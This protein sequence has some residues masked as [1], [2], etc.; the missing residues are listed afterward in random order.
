M[1][2]FFLFIQSVERLE[3][4]GSPLFHW[5]TTTLPLATRRVGSH[6]PLIEIRRQP[7]VECFAQQAGQC[8]RTTLGRKRDRHTRSTHD[9]AGIRTRVRGIVDSIHKHLPMLCRLEHLLVDLRRRRRNDIPGTI[10][11]GRLEYTLRDRHAWL[12]QFRSNLWCDDRHE[13]TVSQKSCEFRCGNLSAAYEEN[14]P[15]SQ[16]Q[17]DWIHNPVLTL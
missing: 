15:T 4:H 8:G 11:I 3:Q 7:R 5:H 2:V 12:M 17:E 10:E 1:T 16:L 13:R 14:S 6:H 9:A